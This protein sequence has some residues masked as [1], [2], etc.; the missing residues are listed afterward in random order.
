[1]DGRSRNPTCWADR[2]AELRCCSAGPEMAG[3]WEQGRTLE[4]CCAVSIEGGFSSCPAVLIV[5]AVILI[6]CFREKRRQ[7]IMQQKDSAKQGRCIESLQQNLDAIVHGHGQQQNP[8]TSETRFARLNQ[9]PHH[10]TQAVYTP[11]VPP[12]QNDNRQEFDLVAFSSG[13]CFFDHVGAMLLEVLG[14]L[15]GSSLA[16]WEC[17][18]TRALH[19]STISLPGLWRIVHVRSFG[20][21][22]PQTLARQPAQNNNGTGGG[23]AA[24][25]GGM[26][27]EWWLWWQRTKEQP[28][29]ELQNTVTRLAKQLLERPGAGILAM[30]NIA[31]ATLQPMRPSDSWLGNLLVMLR[32][33]LAV[34]L[35]TPVDTRLAPLARRWH[36]HALIV[37]EAALAD[38]QG[39][40]RDHVRML[41]SWSF[42]FS[43]TLGQPRLYFSLVW[44]SAAGEA[45]EVDLFHCKVPAR[46]SASWESIAD[47]IVQLLV[48]GRS[49][50]SALCGVVRL[51]RLELSG[52]PTWTL[53][54]C[55]LAPVLS[56]GTIAKELF[57]PQGGI[58][59]TL[60]P[61]GAD[62]RNAGFEKSTEASALRALQWLLAATCPNPFAEQPHALRTVSDQLAPVLAGRRMR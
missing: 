5:L 30:N 55:E 4:T 61:V 2:E 28:H 45:W 41:A 27:K 32:E 29:E 35:A 20:G 40:H 53:R 14:A 49:L 51:G 25:R 1:M 31:Q 37:S 46:A 3:C 18:G 6:L 8:Q 7:E 44:H 48:A 34:D 52:P 23:G 15:D 39:F 24:G 62:S 60:G 54:Q 33:H 57:G 12:S 19:Y 42:S 9:Q 11:A 50:A 22:P 26:W 17:V 36:C 13:S 21:K 16:R 43:A 38:E 56:I 59:S 58:A 47:E 10:E